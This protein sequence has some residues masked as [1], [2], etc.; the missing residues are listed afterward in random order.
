M[1]FQSG[2][3]KDKNLIRTKVEKKKN[4]KYSKNWNNNILKI[5]KKN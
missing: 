2:E 3:Y 4:P 1:F 5:K